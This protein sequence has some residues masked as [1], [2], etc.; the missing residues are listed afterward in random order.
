[1]VTTKP[2]AL[3]LKIAGLAASVSLASLVVAPK[4]NAV[5]LFTSTDS[6]ATQITE[7]NG[8]PKLKVS[9]YTAGPG[10]VINAVIVKLTASLKSSGTIT[11]TAAQAQSFT[12]RTRVDQYDFNP[13]TGAPVALS[14]LSPFAPLA[15]IGQQS[16]TLLAPNTPTNFGPGTASAS[17]SVSFTG[18]QIAQFLGS[19]TFG[20]DP[21]TLIL[22]AVS[23]GGG[24]VTTNITTFADAT[25]EV[26]YVGERTPVP[27]PTTMGLLASVGGLFAM[28]KRFGSQKNKVKVSN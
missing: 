7:L 11:N 6:F 21:S 28:K 14:T 2:V 19:G 3:S 1:V 23:G 4:A 26:E 18:T 8:A 9:K 15:V 12:V 5:S 16:Y 20:F 13:S 22:T 25:L 27:E 10:E 17:T 24:N